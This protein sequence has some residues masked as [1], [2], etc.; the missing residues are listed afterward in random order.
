MKRLILLIL[1]IFILL[2]SLSAQSRPSRALQSKMLNQKPGYITFNEFTGGIGL[3]KKLVPHS[4]Y[5]YGL[6]TVHGY[7]IGKEF[8]LSA[9]TG[10]SFY[11]DGFLVP[12]FLDLRYRIFIS[13]L[14]TYAFVDGG[15]LLDLSAM[16]DTK[17]LMSPGIGATYSFSKNFAA[18][19]GAGIFSQFEDTRDSFI[20]LRAGVTY[21]F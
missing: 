17:L 15:F 6:T 18:N 10:I 12:V 11:G 13:R 7:Q 1:L 3:A 21:K 2:P 14:T 20:N 16:S 9:G 4:Q 19:I 5:F 8:A